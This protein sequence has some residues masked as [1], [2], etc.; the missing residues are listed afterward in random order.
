MLMNEARSP[1]VSGATLL[2]QEMMNKHERK[3]IFRYIF[4]YCTP[5]AKNHNVIICEELSNKF[6]C[7]SAVKVILVQQH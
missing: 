6:K 7:V 5:C 4:R 2:M 3:N 1:S